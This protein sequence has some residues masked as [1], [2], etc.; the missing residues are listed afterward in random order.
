MALVAFTIECDSEVELRLAARGRDQMVSM[1]GWLN[2]LQHLDGGPRSVAALCATTFTKPAQTAFVV[3]CL[4]RWGFVVV[5]PGADATPRSV[6]APGFGS[7]KGVTAKAIVG[8][9]DHGHAASGTWAD[10]IG[11]VESRWRSR[12]GP[13]VEAAVPALRA[14]VAAPGVAMPEG[15]PSG[16]MQGDWRQFPEGSPADPAHG[17]GWPVLLGRALLATTIG[18][19]QRSAVPLA[20]AANTLRVVGNGTPLAELPGLTGVPSEAT[21]TQCTELT[22]RGFVEVVP[23]PAGRGKALRLTAT[24]RAAQLAHRKAAADAETALGPVGARARTALG[25]LLTHAAG[26]QLSLR[27]A[28]VPPAG[29]RR[30]GAV[31]T[32]LERAHPSVQTRNRELVAQTTAFVTDPLRALPHHPVWQGTRNFGP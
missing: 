6:R 28:L 9:T 22:R 31:D 13:T 32:A 27:A 10:V 21:G 26:G 4:E 30:S 15:V 18:Y 19:E 29:V 25:A 16:W 11:E 24:G 2:V 5:T 1:V 17:F 14:V 7:S 3:G 23:N 20:L 12:F 8:L